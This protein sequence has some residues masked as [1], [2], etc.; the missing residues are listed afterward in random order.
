MDGQELLRELERTV[1]ELAAFNEIGKALTSTL[2]VHEVLATVMQ[3]VSDLL[4]PENWSLL[5]VDERTG[6][7]RFEI[8]VGQGA[9]RIKPLRVQLG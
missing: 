4:R 8:A 1:N 5:L 9:E 7:L 2:D 6:D 3:K